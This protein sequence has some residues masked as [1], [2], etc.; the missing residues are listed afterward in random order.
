MEQDEQIVICDDCHTKING[1]QEFIQM[2]REK[3]SQV[4]EKLDQMHRGGSINA[5]KC[6]NCQESPCECK[7]LGEVTEEASD[8]HLEDVTNDEQLEGQ[9]MNQMTVDNM[10]AVRKSKIKFIYSNQRIYTLN[11]IF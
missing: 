4:K 3:S 9:L 6:E 8:E 7:R 2:A 10:I 5:N 1:F 11:Q